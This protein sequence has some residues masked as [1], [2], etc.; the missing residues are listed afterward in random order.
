MDNQDESV[1]GQTRSHGQGKT[2]RMAL[3]KDLIIDV[4]MARNTLGL[5]LEQIEGAL[6]A[7]PGYEPTRSDLVRMLT[8]VAS[9][10]H[11]VHRT[12]AGVERRGK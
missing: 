5:A 8:L 11:L 3:S 4:A 12:L 9:D 2:G 1:G 6:D 10:L 7:K